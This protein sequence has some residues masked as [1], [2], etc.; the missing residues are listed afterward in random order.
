MEY[1]PYSWLFITLVGLLLGSFYACSGYR[2]PNKI[3]MIKSRSF[4]PHCKN[5]IKWWMNIPVLSYIFLGGRCFYCKKKISLMY[6][7]VEIT[8]AFLAT[9][10]YFKFGL[11]TD[12]L[13]FFTLSS[14]FMVTCVS[15][16]KYY[17]VS[18]RVLVISGIV[19]FFAR[20][21]EYGIK[22][23]LYCLGSGLIMFLLMILV[24]VL[25]NIAFKKE[26]LGWGDIKIM[27]IVGFAL[28]D[29]LM[30]S[31]RNLFGTVPSLFAVAFA[32][33]LA[34]P[35]ALYEMFTNKDQ[36]VAFGPYLFLGAMIIMYFYEPL[37]FAFDNWFLG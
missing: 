20:L 6:P 14:A 24:R 3:S 18:D 36:I 10:G 28:G 19:I 21:I 23:T 9:I 30:F 4:C 1:L 2:I 25:G 5:T 13:V 22:G 12:F 7:I 17:Y 29:P 8:T 32:A 26:S 15:D 35:F 16:F 34:L 27:A 33:V 11:T 31:L 37:K